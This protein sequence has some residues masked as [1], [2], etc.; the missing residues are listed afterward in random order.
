MKKL[1]L[2]ILF[3]ILSSNTWAEA[4]CGDCE[5]RLATTPTVSMRNTNTASLS[6]LS[7]QVESNL[8]SPEIDHD[9]NADVCDYMIDGDF[10]YV[11]ELLNDAGHKLEDVFNSINCGTLNWTLFHVI[12]QNALVHSRQKLWNYLDIVKSNDPSFKYESILNTIHGTTAKGTLI[13]YIDRRL[14]LTS[15][16]FVKRELKKFRLE[17]IERGGKRISEL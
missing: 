12:N 11:L 3:M 4:D 15:S 17:V 6:H 5:S 1:L 8:S 13:D 2:A 7:R 10:E 16:E 14:A 9:L